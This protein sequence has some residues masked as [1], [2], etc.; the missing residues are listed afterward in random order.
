[1]TVTH[2]QTI[3]V[4]VSHYIPKTLE[5][6][7]FIPFFGMSPFPLL[8]LR[9]IGRVLCCRGALGVYLLLLEEIIT[10]LV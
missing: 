10:P 8:P 2:R 6:I 9:Q 4:A 7:F 3:S 5:Y 1:M